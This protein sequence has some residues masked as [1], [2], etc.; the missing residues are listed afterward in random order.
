MADK[1]WKRT[2]RLIAKKMGGMRIPVSGVAR[3]F[4]GDILHDIFHVEV[5]Y[6]KQIPKTVYE[7][8]KKTKKQCPKEKI[9]IVVMKPKNSKKNFVL[10]ELDDFMRVVRRG[11]EDRSRG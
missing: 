2:E 3:G 5:K 11:K 6:G 4:K 8:Y 10:I 9:P 7:W 1:N